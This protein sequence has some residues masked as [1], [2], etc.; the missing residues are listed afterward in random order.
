MRSG[1]CTQTTGALPV[2]SQTITVT[3]CNSANLCQTSGG[4]SI[5]PYGATQGVPNLHVSNKDGNSITFSWGTT[6]SNGRP[7]TG[8]E[9]N[10][11]RNQTVGAGTHSTTFNNLGYSRPRPIRVRAIAQDSGPGPWTAK[12][13]GT[14]DPKP[15]PPGPVDHRAARGP[16]RADLHTCAGLHE[17]ELPVGHLHPGQLRRS[18]QLLRLG[19]VQQPDDGTGGSHEPTNGFNQSHK[20]YGFPQGSVTVD[21]PRR[22]RQTEGR[23]QEPVGRLTDRPRTHPLTARR[24]GSQPSGI[25][26]LST[27]STT[28]E[29]HP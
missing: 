22:R 18:H 10:G 19:V 11:D 5:S 15:P 24:G 14:T 21:L 3:T 20:F 13:S 4:A 6:A 7:I 1:S 29:R 25:R 26:T 9:I 28:G 17:P 12:V 8:Y 23:H 2:G 27:S 16:V